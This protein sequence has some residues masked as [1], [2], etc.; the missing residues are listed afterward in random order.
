MSKIAHLNYDVCGVGNRVFQ[1]VEARLWCEENGYTLSH[2]G[3]PELNIP[4]EYLGQSQYVIERPQ[5][6]L[7]DYN[8]YSEH[9]DKI[10]S[11]D[12]FDPVDESEINE[13]D[14]VIH[15]RAGNRF[16]GKN[17]LYSPTS[18][19]YARALDNIEFDNL[20]IVTN[21][22]KY[23]EWDEQDIMEL[24]DKL[25][26]DGGDGEPAEIYEKKYPFLT[27]NQ[28]L[29]F[30]NDHINFFN[31]YNPNWVS[32]SVLEDFNYLRKFKKILFPRS[33]FSWWA[34]VT[35]V[36][37]EVY[38]YGPWA[39]HKQRTNGWLGETNYKGWKSWK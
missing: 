3:I 17:A 22:K 11:W 16:V 31:Q 25:R 18:E 12:C 14:L 28:A 2:G 35:G 8:L 7:Q 6:Y 26:K 4:R 38:V 39:P 34:A 5:R 13:K 37:E 30:T 15:L 20:H 10:K 24:I 33:T 36:A 19:N 9:L 32:G 21:L 27:V 23:D 29:E 1:Y